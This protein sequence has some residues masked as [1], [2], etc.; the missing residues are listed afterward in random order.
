[1]KGLTGTTQ[2][3]VNTDVGCGVT[4]DGAPMCWG[5]NT[6]GQIGNGTR[7]YAPTATPVTAAW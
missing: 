6:A 4:A 5:S 2:F 3:S 1:V 7:N